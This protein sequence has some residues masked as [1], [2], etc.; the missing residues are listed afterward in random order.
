MKKLWDKVQDMIYKNP[1]GFDD[2]T[3]NYRDLFPL[4]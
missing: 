4:K 3:H 2:E 1:I